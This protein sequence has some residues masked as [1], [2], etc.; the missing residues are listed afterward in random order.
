MSSPSAELVQ[1]SLTEFFRAKSSELDD[2]LSSG[3]F[4]LAEVSESGQVKSVQNATPWFLL[5]IEQYVS[6]G[7]TP[8]FLSTEAKRVEE[9]RQFLTLQNQDVVRRSLEVETRREQIQELER[10][11]E[12]KRTKLENLR[13]ALAADQAA[14]LKKQEA[15]GSDLQALEQ[16]QQAWHNRKEGLLKE[17]AELEQRKRK[18]AEDC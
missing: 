7:L 16:Q 15:L 13:Q 3:S 17:L 9:W 10:G 4:V 6:Q 2:E 18:L 12:D 1:E 11:L 8:E 14:L 5:L